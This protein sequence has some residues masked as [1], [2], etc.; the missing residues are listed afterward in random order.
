MDTHHGDTHRPRTITY[1][2]FNVLIMRSDILLHQT[3]LHDQVQRVQNLQAHFLLWQ[4]FKQG[5][6]LYV[7]LFVLCQF[8]L[9]LRTL[10]VDIAKFIILLLPYFQHIFAPLKHNFCFLLNWV[11]FAALFKLFHV[12]VLLVVMFADFYHL[13]KCPRAYLYICPLLSHYFGF[14]L[15][16]CLLRLFRLF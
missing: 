3:I 4:Q 1:R 9:T 7:A 6:N 5:F 13:G 12:K 8:N 11:P 2:E 10:L 14:F 15:Q 16:G